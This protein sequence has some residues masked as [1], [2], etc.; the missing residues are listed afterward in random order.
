MGWF[1][2]LFPIE[3]NEAKRLQ[4]QVNRL[5][6]KIELQEGLIARMHVTL[7]YLR[8]E[9]AVMSNSGEST[10]R[11]VER[12]QAAAAAILRDKEKILQ[13]T[14]ATK[15]HFEAIQHSARVI[16]QKNYV[17]VIRALDVQDAIFAFEMW[18]DI[19]SIGQLLLA[20]YI[21][22]MR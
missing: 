3:A 11:K 8:A 5:Q 20:Y 10:M 7:I 15:E 16:T 2:M 1:D 4:E 19:A 13:N 21:L 9:N 14:G 18:V 6:Q 12:F 17:T 22:S